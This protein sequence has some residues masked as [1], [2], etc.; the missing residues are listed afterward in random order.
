[1]HEHEISTL[2]AG[3]HPSGSI[4]WVNEHQR[5]YELSIAKGSS[6]EHTAARRMTILD[7]LRFHNPGKAQNPQPFL[8]TVDFAH[9]VRIVNGRDTDLEHPKSTGFFG[10]GKKP[11]YL[12]S[13]KMLPQKD[14]DPIYALEYFA[15]V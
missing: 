4:E 6:P 12:Q 10:M 13:E 9:P 15:K 5:A 14:A 3:P 7:F 8:A 1:M 11:S 2:P